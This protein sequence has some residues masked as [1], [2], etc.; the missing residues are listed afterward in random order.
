MTGVDED[1]LERKH[2][3]MDKIRTMS[4]STFCYFVC[5]SDSQLTAESSPEFLQ[6]VLVRFEQVE[7]GPGQY[8]FVLVWFDHVRSSTAVQ[9]RL[10]QYS[11]RIELTFYDFSYG[12]IYRNR[13]SRYRQRMLS[14]RVLPSDWVASV[15]AREIM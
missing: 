10:V 2:I 15:Q 7:S 12:Q 14:F 5:P 4:K 1:T 3:V 11:S 8:V 6:I 9:S 13:V